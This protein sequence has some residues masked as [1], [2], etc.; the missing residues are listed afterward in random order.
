[1]LHYGVWIVAIPVVGLRAAPWRLNAV[2]LAR[3]ARAWRWGLY[4]VL[5]GG[6]LAVVV[7]WACFL[8]DYT[9]TSNVYFTVALL[10]VLAEAPFL[11]RAL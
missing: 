6:A 7:L 8:A 3:R 1:M 4:A 2:P 9:L 5:A 10:H 11:L